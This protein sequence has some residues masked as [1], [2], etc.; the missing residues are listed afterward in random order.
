M[1]KALIQDLI[2]DLI[3]DFTVAD[4]RVGESRVQKAELNER[5][6]DECDEAAVHVVRLS[7]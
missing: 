1:Q 3:E 5:T 6:A 4:G 2:E 7:F